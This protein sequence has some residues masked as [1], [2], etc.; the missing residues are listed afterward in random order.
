MFWR[1][2][3]E[4]LWH[5]DV[6]EPA[7]PEDGT[8]NAP[9]TEATMRVIRSDAAL[10][11]LSPES[12]RFAG[13]PAILVIAY[14]SPH[15]DFRQVVARL[16]LLSAPA[17]LIAVTT[18][19]E[20]C[21]PGGA[22]ARPAQLYCPAEGAWNNLVVQIFG[23]DLL[24]DVSVHSIP[25]ANEDIRAG[26]PEKPVAQRLEEIG[27]HLDRVQPPFPIRHDDTL[28]LTLIDGLSASENFFMEAVY[29]SGR[30]PCIFIGGSSATQKNPQG[31]WLFDGRDFVQHCALV[32]FVKMQE[33]ARFGIFKTQN[34]VPVG[35]SLVV[36]EGTVETRQIT[37]VAQQGTVDIVPVIDAMCAMMRC[38]PRELKERMRHH[39]F[40]IVMNGEL[41]VRSASDIDIENGVV[42]FY[43]EVN[44]GDELHLVR[45]TDF[46]EQTRR[47]LA[48][49]LQGKPEPAG[50]VLNDCIQRR[51]KNP[52]QLHK[53]DGL[54]GSA[55]VAGFSTFGELL[56]INL[57]LTLTAAVFFRVAPGEAFH[58]PYIDRFPI[59]YAGFAHYFVETRLN[60]Q[61]LMNELRQKLI[62]GLVDFVTRASRLTLELD[63]AVSGT[64][65]ARRHVESMR[66]QAQ[67][68]IHKMAGNDRTGLLDAEFRRVSA[69]TQRLREIVAV[70]DN[71]NMQTNLLSLNA[72][73]EA[74]R[75][76]EAGRAFAVVANEVRSLANVTRDTL[77]QSKGSF[78][79]VEESMGL[80]GSHVAASEAKLLGAREGLG[81]IA[82][83]LDQMFGSFQSITALLGMVEQ[84]AQQQRAMMSRI[85]QD[86]ERLRHIER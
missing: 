27:A 55:P 44:A 18:A 30:F 63:Q 58:D 79:E 75:A 60:Q 16:R 7:M 83:S 39:D 9:Q 85:E 8:H 1:R 46:A 69:T 66:I 2:R 25:L 80:L 23:A 6:P 21:D 19:G 3:R 59:Y 78:E 5:E 4:E 43:C 41:F 11:N 62:G 57:N 48:S 53:L 42:T 68:Q 20:L 64:E 32:A 35:K 38:Q 28:A 13:A 45:T 15:V 34:V 22:Q 67:E 26:H 72:G 70:I 76:G 47:D 14:I 84:M 10:G 77:D 51:T 50:V 36:M 29:K 17:R 12:F 71:I 73:I 49:F 54:W 61:R 65:E 81:V 52:G 56:G 33:H 37:T 74:A 31:T 40:A 86:T 82:S 24:R